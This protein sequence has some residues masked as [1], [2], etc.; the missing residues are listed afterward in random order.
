MEVVDNVFYYYNVKTEYLKFV[1]SQTTTKP[2][3][4]E[5]IGVKFFESNQ[6]EKLSCDQKT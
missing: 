3:A 6:A 4:S 2:N 5:I 1:L